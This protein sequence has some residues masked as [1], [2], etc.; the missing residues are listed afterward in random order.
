[1]SEDDNNNGGRSL[2]GGSSEPLPSSWSQP[3]STRRVGRIGD[4]NNS[5]GYVPSWRPFT[6]RGVTCRFP[7]DLPMHRATGVELVFHR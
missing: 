2:G 7:S 6:V 5:S 4:W 1:M 3:S